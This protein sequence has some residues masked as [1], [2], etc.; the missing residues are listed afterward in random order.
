MDLYLDLFSLEK[1]ATPR[2]LPSNETNRENRHWGDDLIDFPLKHADFKVGFLDFQPLNCCVDSMWGV[3]TS[4][5]RWLH[6]A[7]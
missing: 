4:Q 3:F 2:A 6:S 7:S 1:P 5:I